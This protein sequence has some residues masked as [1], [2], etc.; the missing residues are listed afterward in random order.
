[1][2]GNQP[3][4]LPPPGISYN[5]VA[6]PAVLFSSDPI[7]SVNAPQVARSLSL[8]KKRVAK[9]VDKS[10]RFEP[11]RRPAPKVLFQAQGVTQTTNTAVP[12]TPPQTGSGLQTSQHSY[13]VMNEDPEDIEFENT[14]EDEIN[15]GAQANFEILNP[16]NL[17]EMVTSLHAILNQALQTSSQPI[18]QQLR[19]INTKLN[20]TNKQLKDRI[21]AME[22]QAK[23][24]DMLVYNLPETSRIPGC[25]RADPR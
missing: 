3:P 12:S 16:D 19:S 25:Y 5:P 4:N 14:A 13:D 22:D 17:P 10:H 11:I 8:I 9:R 6:V 20:K 18:M 1:M 24:R 7:G 21:K 15:D 2:N 23:T